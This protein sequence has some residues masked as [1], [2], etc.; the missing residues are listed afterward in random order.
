MRVRCPEGL[1]PG[2]VSSLSKRSALSSRVKF[3]ADAF[4]S[5]G[6]HPLISYSRTP[7]AKLKRILNLS[8][9]GD[10]G[11]RVEFSYN[12]EK[13][14]VPFRQHIGKPAEP[15]VTKGGKVYAGDKIA[16][17]GKDLGREIHAPM[18]GAVVANSNSAIELANC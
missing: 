3:D 10:T 7:T 13:L 16:T 17:V 15:T 4:P 6:P 12:P 5:N 18:T 1:Y 14:T 2:S 11:P 8:R 9:F